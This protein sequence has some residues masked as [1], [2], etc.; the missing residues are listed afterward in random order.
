MQRKSIR[1]LSL[2]IIGKCIRMKLKHLLISG[3]AM[4]ALDFVYLSAFSKFFNTLVRSIQ[5]SP[6]QF[7]WIGAALCYVFLIF[8]LNYFIIDAKKPLMDAFLFGLVIYGVYETTNYALLDKWSAKAVVL[9]TL[10]GGILMA[11]TTKITYLL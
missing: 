5:G 8:G 10:W 6:I 1:L 4:L 3:L 11:L 9:D 7:K 2:L